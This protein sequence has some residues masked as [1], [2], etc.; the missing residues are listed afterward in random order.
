MQTQKCPNE[1][2]KCSTR[3]RHCNTLQTSIVVCKAHFNAQRKYMQKLDSSQVEQMKRP[4]K[5]VMEKPSET[6]AP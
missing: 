3:Y 4:L 2:Q 1:K 5:F 6:L